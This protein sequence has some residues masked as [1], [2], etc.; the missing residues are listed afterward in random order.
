VRHRYRCH[1][2]AHGNIRPVAAVVR[3]SSSVAAATSSPPPKRRECCGGG[4]EGT[5]LSSVRPMGRG[6]GGG[7]I[8]TQQTPSGLRRRRRRP[9]RS[10]ND[11]GPAVHPSPPRT[12]ACVAFPSK[13]PKGPV[14]T[15]DALCVLHCAVLGARQVPEFLGNA[16]A[17][18][19]ADGFTYLLL[20]SENEFVSPD[21][22]R[23]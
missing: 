13:P 15:A 10:L 21:D 22:R 8:L 6:V 18:A 12:C 16:S 19:A 7:G 4:A 1:G 20:R 2:R 9:V 11:G 3:S 23:R 5:I 14:P 17:A